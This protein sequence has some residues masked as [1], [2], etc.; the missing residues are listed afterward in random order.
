MFIGTSILEFPSFQE[1]LQIENF[2]HLVLQLCENDS[3]SFVRAS[4]LKCL[5]HMIKGDVLWK[6]F[7]E[8]EQLPVN[9]LKKTF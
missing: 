8:Q 1:L 6:E 2:P 4:A 9:I 5:Q 7:F 3:E